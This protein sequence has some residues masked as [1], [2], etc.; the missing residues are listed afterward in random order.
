MAKAQEKLAQTKREFWKTAAKGMLVL[1]KIV[2]LM[3]VLI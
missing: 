1:G 3:V 2:L